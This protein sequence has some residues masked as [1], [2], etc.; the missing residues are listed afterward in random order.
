MKWVKN[1]KGRYCMHCKSFNCTCLPEGVSITGKVQ[2]S[3]SVKFLK[4]VG[5][6]GKAT[7]ILLA[8][9]ILPNDKIIRSRTRLCIPKVDIYH[10]CS[11]LKL[12]KI[13]NRK[14]NQISYE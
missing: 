10:Y 3:T 6:T 2:L 1:D 4:I 14:L 5:D 13:S 11:S 9:N 12:I 8:K 7:I